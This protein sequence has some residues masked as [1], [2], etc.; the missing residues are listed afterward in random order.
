V[1][2]KPTG[3]VSVEYIDKGAVLDE[4]GVYRYLLWRIWDKSKPRVTFIMLNPSTADANIDDAT[5]RRCVGFADT[6][7]Y[8]GMEVVNLF[9]YR[10]THPEVLKLCDDP[11]GPENDDYIFISSARS[12]MI[13]AAWGT[14]GGFKNRDKA[15]LELIRNVYCIDVS[16]EGH[17]KHPLYLKSDL[18]PKLLTLKNG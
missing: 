18:K 13:I 16:K 15:V 9:A 12:M 11:I 2:S 17:P 5:I 4:T 1:L 8:G 14:N 10:A 7:G 6:W 3:G